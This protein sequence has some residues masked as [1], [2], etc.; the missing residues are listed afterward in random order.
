MVAKVQALAQAQV[1][2]IEPSIYVGDDLW[3]S[4]P[5]MPDPHSTNRY[6]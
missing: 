4:F 3:T 6:P 5:H 2:I 1:A